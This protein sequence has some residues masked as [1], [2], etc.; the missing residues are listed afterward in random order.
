[1]VWFALV[2][3]ATKVDMGRGV[4]GGKAS[5]FIEIEHL[6][7]TGCL[8]NEKSEGRRVSFTLPWLSDAVTVG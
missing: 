4:V 7:E 3:H 1:V 2:P 6:R 5:M 8:G